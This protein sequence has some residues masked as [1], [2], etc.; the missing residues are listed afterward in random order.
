MTDVMARVRKHY[1]RAVQHYG[2]DAVFG[3]FHYGSWN[4]GTNLPDSDVDTKCILIPDL[5]HLAIKPY[6]TKHLHVDDE[7]CECMTVM[8][9]VAN[10]KKQNINFLEIMSTCYFKVNPKYED[11][12]AVDEEPD[13]EANYPLTQ[14]WAERVARYDIAAAVRSMANQAINTLKRNPGDLKA[15]TN[16]ARI[17]KALSQLTDKEYRPYDVCIRA[18]KIIAGIRT[19]E[20][21][22]SAE[23]VNGL[24][25]FFDALLVREKEG[26][27]P[28]NPDK[29]VIDDYL[30]HFILDLI[31]RRMSF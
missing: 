9:M 12:W 31:Q 4:Y 15:I 3:V 2:E 21:P 30:N 8:H 18:N 20:T 11:W 28:P 7:V 17:A 27:Y 1:E 29:D 19:G 25:G 14:F 6:E 10:W 13:S 16:G 23:Y 5:Y 24:I 26:L 22:I